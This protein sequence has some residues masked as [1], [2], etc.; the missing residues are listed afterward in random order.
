MYVESVN[1][2]EKFV[3][4]VVQESDVYAA[5]GVG[6]AIGYL[7]GLTICVALLH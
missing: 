7:A 4:K 5:F 2:T 1:M 6:L 3:D